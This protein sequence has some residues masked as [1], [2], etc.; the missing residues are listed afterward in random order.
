MHYQAPVEGA[1]AWVD[2]LSMPVGAENIDQ[3][4][5][6][7][8]FAYRKEP[9]GQAI[10]SHCYNSPVTGADEFAGETYRKNFAEAYPGDSLANLNPWPAEAPW[11]AALRSEYVKAFIAG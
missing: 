8:D 7:I 3:V 2:G 6:F 10:D 4:Y 1:M 5:A 9:A 11:Y